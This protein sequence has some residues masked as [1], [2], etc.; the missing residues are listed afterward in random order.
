MEKGQT[1]NLPPARPSRFDSLATH[2]MLSVTIPA[3]TLHERDA[4]R[5]HINPDGTLGYTVV[6]YEESGEFETYDCPECSADVRVPGIYADTFGKEAT[7]AK[8]GTVS[9]VEHD[10]AW[11]TDGDCYTYLMRK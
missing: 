2:H 11:G 6:K 1:V 5:L 7:C 10:C 3:G 8:C 4:F 9:V